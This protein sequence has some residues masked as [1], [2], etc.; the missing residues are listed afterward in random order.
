MSLSAV[1][2]ASSISALL[3]PTNTGKT[4]RAVERML[5]HPTGMIG[6]PLRLL[7]REIYDRLT[8]RLGEAQV[9]LVT[10]EEKRVGPRPRFWV[11]TTEAMPLDREVDFVAIDEI[12]L[13]AHTQRGHVFTHRLLHARG[14]AETW[15]LGS[16]SMRARVEELVPTA[17]LRS[18]PRLSTLRAAPSATLGALPPRSALIAFSVPEVYELADRVRRRRGGAAVVHGALSPRTRNAQVAMFQAGEV[19]CLVATDAIGMGLN[20]DIDHVAFAELHKFD[21]RES[22]ALSAA[23]LGQI[24]GRAG[25]HCADGTFGALSP[26][27]LPPPVA[28]DIEHH[29]FPSVRRVVWRSADLDPSSLDALG[30]SL[31]QRPTR[32]SFQLVE[33][34]DDS[35]VLGLLAERPEIRAR[36]V[37]AERVALLWEVCQ[38]PDFR[39]ILLEHHA[40]LCGEI[41]LQLTG[42]RARLNPDWLDE[43]VRRLEDTGGSIDELLMRM[44]AI[45]IWSYVAQRAHWLDDARHWQGRTR[46]AEDALSEALHLRLVERFVERR[47]RGGRSR[48]HGAR[49][50]ARGERG[51][52]LPAGADGPFSKLGQL[53]LAA[54][55][56]PEPGARADDAHDG[57]VDELCEAPHERFALDP[58]GRVL[59]LGAAPAPGSER[60]ADKPVAQLN[61]GR[62]LLHPEVRLT[63]ARDPGAGG[64]ARIGRRLAAWTRDLVEEAL[65]PLH[66]ERLRA[67]SAAGRGLVYQLEQGL[68]TARAA[69]GQ[70]QIAQLTAR[71]RELCAEV[72]IELGQFMLYAPALLKPAAVL[73]RVAL[74]TALLGRRAALPAPSPSRVSLAASRSIPPE[75]YL[76]IGYPVLGPRAIRADLAERAHARLCVAAASA[77]LA[78]PPGLGS[79]IGCSRG[80]LGAVVA[81]FGFGPPRAPEEQD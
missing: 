30:A 67:L 36:A 46:S 40:G 25:R 23:E 22:R 77:P 60:R 34:A 63:L 39:K 53:V 76:A 18:H 5:E 10:G 38:I 19:D 15:L 48:A 37:G 12:Q 65:A 9:A 14:R 6:L 16:D 52:E 56:E 62:D 75:I 3:G 59:D 17:M 8:L 43:R 33:R 66:D 70:A 68:G 7:A 13:C 81:A 79:L 57:W 41:F 71:D 74:C 42:A 2:G 51:A 69:G 61:R 31:R 20:L 1:G 29:R 50:G 44:E 47:A 45:R 28:L 24:A 54:R 4:H 73:R 21:G 11:C 78:V 72:G 58:S 27:V 35:T 32:P 80:E 64:R 55:R 26:R 49:G